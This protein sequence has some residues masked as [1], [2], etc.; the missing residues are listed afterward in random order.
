MA[1]NK[2]LTPA[3]ILQLIQSS[4]GDL[5]SI[6]LSKKQLL[7]AL[8]SSPTLLTQIQS[9]AEQAVS[10][11]KQFDPT[12][13]YDPNAEA[14]PVQYKYMAMGEKYQPFVQ[15]YWA[16]VAR[17]PS[18]T[19]I[20]A[21]I[22]KTSAELP[23]L[24]KKY[25]I[26]QAEL[27]SITATMND[28]KEVANFQKQEQARQKKQYTQ[29]NAKKLKLGIG[30]P[31]T[32]TEDYL[33]KTTGLAGLGEIPTV[34]KYLAGKKEKY[35]AGLAGKGYNEAMVFNRGEE[36]VK[37]LAGK[38]KKSKKSVAQLTAADLIKKNLKGL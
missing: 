6:G 29:F 11:Y 38:M 13:V 10:P 4:G 32:A 23:L 22:A 14:N 16:E 17:N 36:L 30:S 19:G 25:N 20:Q 21:H 27:E 37:Q 18:P 35:T 8:L 28:P 1:S 3:Q 2:N 15:D 26:P 7:S 33:K 12:F 5:A 24:A 9:G 34:E 31:E